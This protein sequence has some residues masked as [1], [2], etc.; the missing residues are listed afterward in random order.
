MR[1]RSAAYSQQKGTDLPIER[2]FTPLGS[3]VLTDADA[4][5]RKFCR[6]YSPNFERGLPGDASL[7]QMER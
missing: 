7:P 4:A 2:V 1:V 6:G 5:T 3:S